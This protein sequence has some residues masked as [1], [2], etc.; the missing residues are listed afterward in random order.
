ML[1][2]CT[3]ELSWELKWE[4]GRIEW[5]F[6]RNPV[7]KNE[8]CWR[9]RGLAGRE[10]LDPRYS[11]LPLPKS[12]FF[13]WNILLSAII[14]RATVSDYGIST[15]GEGWDF[16][17]II[18]IF[19]QRN[20]FEKQKGLCYGGR[21]GKGGGWRGCRAGAGHFPL[22]ALICQLSCRQDEPGGPSRLPGAV[23]GIAAFLFQRHAE[24]WW[25]WGAV[26]LG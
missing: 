6:H 25:D 13:F 3:F 12:S 19:L 1:F 2:L 18:A 17:E 24:H 11:P 21:L 26:R 10:R 8:I 20:I 14:K 16:S 7:D 4:R 22:P 23:R 15:S 5:K 9:W